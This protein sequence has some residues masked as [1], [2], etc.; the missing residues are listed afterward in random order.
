MYHLTDLPSFVSG[1]H[2]VLFDPHMCHLRGSRGVPEPG[3][4]IRFTHKAARQLLREHPASFAPYDLFGCAI[5]RRFDG[6]LFRFPLRT[7][8]QAEHSEVSPACY[9]EQSV[10]GILELF[11][12]EAPDLLLFLRNVERIETYRWREGEKAPV[13]TSSAHVLKLSKKLRQQRSLMASPPSAVATSAPCHAVFHIT[14]FSTRDNCERQWLIAQGFGG[15][16]SK[17]LAESAEM[18]LLGLTLL[19]WGGVACQLGPDGLPNAVDGQAYVF[20]PLPVRTGLPVHV[21]GFF[22]VS[23]NR[24]DIWFGTDMQGAG[25]ARSGTFASA[26]LR[27]GSRK[28]RARTPSAALLPTWRRSDAFPQHRC[29]TLLQASE[30]VVPNLL[31]DS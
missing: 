11:E 6:T 25:K 24:R 3:K 7:P 26:G 14:I 19:P 10:M 22:E 28:L 20:L 8:E 9:S 1:E 29:P 17:R 27:D 16:A 21:N 12:S 30:C 23:E 15:E 5:P 31:S 4:R 13:L 18:R 2:L